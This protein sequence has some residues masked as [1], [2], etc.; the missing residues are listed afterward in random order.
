MEQ[1]CPQCHYQVQPLFY[2][3]P[4]CGKN[5]KPAPLSTSIGKQISI[6]ALSVF[7]PPLGIIP[8]MK[9]LFQKDSNAKLVGLIAILLTIISSG[10]T[11]WYT[12]GFINTINK[13]VNSQLN[14]YQDLGF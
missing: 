10:L 8:G 2:F 13:Q 7:L 12:I 3:C 11:V 6:Y 9:Y 5:L 14:N 1:A 4:N